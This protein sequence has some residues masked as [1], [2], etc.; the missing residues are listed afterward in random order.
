[1]PDEESVDYA[2]SYTPEDEGWEPPLI[3]DDVLWHFFCHPSGSINDG[4]YDVE[5]RNRFP[6]RVSPLSYHPNKGYP[7]G[8]GLEF[9][10][11]FNWKLFY[12]CESLIV[13]VAIIVPL[14]YGICSSDG[15]KVSTAFTIGQWLFGAG[16]ILYMVMLALS[17]TLCFWRY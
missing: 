4:V 7:V 14:I 5:C 10:E 6:K 16:Q 9:V 3:A 13:V 11:K 2:Y 17:E 1:M 15:D 8:W 12:H